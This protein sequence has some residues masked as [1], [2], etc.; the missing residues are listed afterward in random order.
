[1]FSAGSL[2]PTI[3]GDFADQLLAPDIN[4]RDELVD[5]ARKKDV[6]DCGGNCDRQSS[7]GCY[8]SLA[9]ASGQHFGAPHGICIR[10]DIERVD[11][12]GDGSE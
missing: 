10:N 4:I 6:G 5:A 8:Q 7:G 3:T 9:N 2:F 1:M 12:S 11:H